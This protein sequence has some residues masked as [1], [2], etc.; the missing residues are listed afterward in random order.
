MLWAQ[1]LGAF[2]AGLLRSPPCHR[3]PTPRFAAARPAPRR[4]LVPPPS[5][6][7]RA[8]HPFSFS[9][10]PFARA[11]Q[12]AAVSAVAALASG[13]TSTMITMATGLNGGEP[14]ELNEKHHF[15]I[16]AG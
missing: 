13:L 2:G 11:G 5:N 3:P 12:I 6:Q 7:T 1:G 10:S 16:F 4:R 9:V 15:G 8:P 14:V